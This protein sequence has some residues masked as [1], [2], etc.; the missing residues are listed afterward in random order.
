MTRIVAGLEELGLARREVDP[1]DRRVARVRLTAEGARRLSRFRNRKDAFVATRL[2]ALS[3]DD[4]AALAAALP[5]L[6]RLLGD[7]D[8]E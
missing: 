8:P 7:E 4:R 6:E 1:G 5:V 2:A 3:D